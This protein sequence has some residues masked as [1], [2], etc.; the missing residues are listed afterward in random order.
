MQNNIQ[1]VFKQYIE[2]QECQINQKIVENAPDSQILD[3]DTQN[4]LINNSKLLEL[5]EN[6]TYKNNLIQLQQICSGK[7]YIFFDKEIEK[8]E[9]QT[10]FAIKAFQSK[11]IYLQEKNIFKKI[12]EKNGN[13]FIDEMVQLVNFDDYSL[14]LFMQLGVMDL[15][16]F[17]EIKQKLNL[18][19]EEKE[20]WY[21]INQ[22]VNLV[23]KLKEFD[24]YHCDIKPGNIYL[25]HS[26][27]ED[28]QYK[29]KLGD[30]GAFLDLSDQKQKEQ[31]IQLKAYSP[32]YMPLKTDLKNSDDLLKFNYFQIGRIIYEIML[33]NIKLENYFTSRD[34]NI[35]RQVI[36][37]K[38]VPKFSEDLIE[39]LNQ[40]LFLKDFSYKS[41]IE[42]K[43]QSQ[44][45]K[46]GILDPNYQIL[47]YKMN[48]RKNQLQKNE[49][50]NKA[51]YFQQQFAE[52]SICAQFQLGKT[53]SDVLKNFK[54]EELKKYDNLMKI[55]EAQIFYKNCLLSFQMV[56]DDQKCEECINN[57][58]I[59]KIDTLQDKNLKFDIENQVFSVRNIFLIKSGK[60]DK[61]LS[62]ID[63]QIE[64]LEQ[65]KNNVDMFLYY[66]YLVDIKQNKGEILRMQNKNQN[67]LQEF[68]K[69]AEYKNEQ[70]KI[71]KE[72]G[73][74]FLQPNQQ[75]IKLVTY[76]EKI[77]IIYADL[78][79][80]ENAKEYYQKALE[81]R[82][83][84]KDQKW[85]YQ[86][87]KCY[88]NLVL[89]EKNMQQKLQY[90]Q[91]KQQIQKM[92][93]SREQKNVLQHRK[94][95]NQAQ[96]LLKKSEIAK[97]KELERKAIE[98]LENLG[99]KDS[100][101]AAHYWVS[102]GNMQ[103]QTDES[104]ESLIS[105][106]NAQEIYESHFPD[107]LESSQYANI[108]NC[109]ASFYLMYQ[110]Y[111][112]SEKYFQLAI[113]ISEKLGK[114][115]E[116]NYVLYAYNLALIYKYQGELQKCVDAAG[117][118]YKI[119]L[120]M[121]KLCYK[122]L[123]KNCYTMGTC[124]LKLEKFQEGKEYLSKSIDYLDLD[125]RSEE[126]KQDEYMNLYNEL[127]YVFFDIK[128]YDLA[129][130]YMLKSVDL[131]QKVI[132]KEQQET[133]KNYFREKLVNSLRIL[134]FSCRADKDLEKYAQY[135][136]QAIDINKLLVLDKYEE[137]E[138]ISDYN[139]IAQAFFDADDYNSSEK[140]F[141]KALEYSNTLKT[142]F[143]EDS[144]ELKDLNY[145]IMVLYKGMIK[146]YEKSGQKEEQ[147]EIQEQLIK[148]RENLKQD[149]SLLLNESQMSQKSN[150][151][152]INITKTEE[153]KEEDNQLIMEY[154]NFGIY[155]QNDKKNLKSAEEMYLKALN[156][157]EE[158]LEEKKIK[159]CYIKLSQMFAGV[160]LEKQEKY[161]QQYVKFLRQ[162]K[163]DKLNSQEE[164][165][166]I[167]VNLGN[168]Y[169]K[170]EKYEEAIRCLESA[171][172]EISQQQSEKENLKMVI[173][174][175]EILNL[176]FE[177]SQQPQKAIDVQ[178][179]IMEFYEIFEMKNDEKLTQLVFNLGYT[180]NENEK[181]DFAYQYMEKAG[182]M[183]EETL[184]KEG[185][186]SLYY[187]I[188]TIYAQ[189]SKFEESL[190]YLEKCLVILEELGKGATIYEENYKDL[191]DFYEN[192]KVMN[193]GF[194]E[195][196]QAEQKQNDQFSSKLEENEEKI[197][198]KS[199][200]KYPE[201]SKNYG[202][203]MNDLLENL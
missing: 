68:L 86:V 162:S 128:C 41:V 193:G 43:I 191:K 168:N 16:K 99:E 48:Q 119:N 3:F 91:K 201:D 45:E 158:I 196:Q 176:C 155:Q 29:L 30:F 9:C 24:I 185:Q 160:D 70:D 120:K 2:G 164:I 141:K 138:F 88:E 179:K 51:I 50:A 116:E 82:L 126:E 46:I 7:V 49:E 75:Q 4:Q 32:P 61:A 156:L 67:S 35:M 175:H 100:Q 177:K 150:N 117:L 187:Q 40:T 65:L 94:Y 14:S 55:E 145:L 108:L 59:Q 194:G 72:C 37:Q 140:Y 144:V 149:D 22:L 190:I 104:E 56:S 167:F 95:H 60:L 192:I 180:Y 181:F 62:L 26:D 57:Y 96:E 203:E 199:G 31:Q 83:Q 153:N 84:N 15:Q 111:E 63:Q 79:Q 171:Y 98:I 178:L 143:D 163:E 154:I 93:E 131:Q 132:D 127:G 135:Y 101:E 53:V 118:A 195:D 136:E 27:E 87:K 76:Y 159:M 106:K 89:L 147:G 12:Y 10:Q 172:Q 33:R 85:L 198:Y 189:R 152:N 169:Y 1:S 19:A 151:N 39:F 105:F 148:F 134:S 23:E 54:L 166:S 28:F 146:L 69:I 6:E 5:S 107:K 13:Q 173:A 182:N 92:I 110:E 139:Q 130:K 174:I 97:A 125:E 200:N 71:S 109:V 58:I 64:K 74:D 129:I 113:D 165:P 112:I 122:N 25:Y 21:A 18:Q 197:D 184:D 81:I 102:L 47:N 202:N 161:S 115:D 73:N 17:F 186:F 52:I 170:E 103:K 137:I 42:Q 77:A 78:Q 123:S 142:Q 34:P 66:K 157:A 90:E 8:A 44:K 188:G 124:L 114:Q 20:I 80:E 183:A 38:L 133:N 121:E 36:E 11:Q